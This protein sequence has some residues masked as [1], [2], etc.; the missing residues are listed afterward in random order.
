MPV[1]LE[2]SSPRRRSMLSSATAAPKAL[3]NV[4]VSAAKDV[5][6]ILD[7]YLPVG[8][9][10]AAEYAME[11]TSSLTGYAGQATALAVNGLDSLKNDV[12]ATV[13]DVRVKVSKTC[14]GTVSLASSAVTA[15]SDVVLSYTPATAVK[16]VNQAINGVDAVRVDGLQGL[17]GFVPVFVIGRSTQTFEIFENVV[18]KPEESANNVT[19]STKT[20]KTTIVDSARSTVQ[21]AKAL[22]SDCYSAAVQAV[23][24]RKNR[25]VEEVT[26]KF[27]ASTGF[28]VA[29]ANGVVK[30]V[31]AIPHVKTLLNK[32]EALTGRNSKI[33]RTLDYIG[34]TAAASFVLSVIIPTEVASQ[35]NAAKNQT[36]KSYDLDSRVVYSNVNESH[37]VEASI[38]NSDENR[39]CDL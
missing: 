27:N 4:S 7:P 22:C 24:E 9:K 26:T 15:T 8:A 29:K 18:Q 11:Q 33:G 23:D 20:A 17:R 21:L 12:F 30:Y 2:Q 35:L 3:L 14:E 32:I 37:D 19:D 5:A 1:A 6:Q 36:D 10:Q 16:L 34:L 39:G 38:L 31:I 25:A 28:I 13:E